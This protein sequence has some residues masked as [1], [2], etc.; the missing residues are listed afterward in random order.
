MVQRVAE[1][2][3]ASRQVRIDPHGVACGLDGPQVLRTSIHIA[4]EHV[5]GRQLGVSEREIGIEGDGLLQDLDAGFILVRRA[6]RESP[7]LQIQFVR[8]RVVGRYP[9]D[10]ASLLGRERRP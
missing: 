6:A 8:L 9:F 4:L 2:V 7:L 3:V 5:S 1:G 10:A